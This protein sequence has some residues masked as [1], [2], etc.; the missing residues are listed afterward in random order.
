MGSSEKEVPGVSSS[1]DVVDDGVPRSAG[2][3][4]EETERPCLGS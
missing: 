2:K 3:R 4:K 1:D